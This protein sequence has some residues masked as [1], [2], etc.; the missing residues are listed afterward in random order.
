M[1]VKETIFYLKQLEKDFNIKIIEIDKHGRHTYYAIAKNNEIEN[2][3]K[4]LKIVKY[5]K[6]KKYV[7]FVN[8]LTY[9]NIYYS[10]DI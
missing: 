8:K 6:L 3:N 10:Q 5:K 4:V 9:G 2:D 7:I 1:Q